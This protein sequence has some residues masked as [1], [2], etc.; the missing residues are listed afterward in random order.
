[1]VIR[2]DEDGCVAAETAPY[3]SVGTGRR[4][5]KV[6]CESCRAPYEIDER[7]VPP[8]GL[9][10]RCSKCGQS[11]LVR[12]GADREGGP[13]PSPEPGALGQS[14]PAVP[15]PSPRAAV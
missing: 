6:E 13:A 11:F 10:V 12:S 14:R 9:K 1:L 2:R 8:A 4:M 5:L 7:R 15:G 3:D